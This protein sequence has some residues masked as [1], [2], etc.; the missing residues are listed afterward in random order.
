M[1]KAVQ[2]IPAIFIMMMVFIV[3][4]RMQGMKK[5]RTSNDVKPF[6]IILCAR[7]V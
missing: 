2:I 6:E 1:T 4:K 5:N 7:Y 3:G